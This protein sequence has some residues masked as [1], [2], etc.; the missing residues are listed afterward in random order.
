MK[1]LI[2]IFRN[3]LD[4]GIELPEIR[5]ELGKDPKGRIECQIG[6]DEKEGLLLTIRND[7]NALDPGLFQSI[8]DDYMSSKDEAG[9]VS[10]RGVGLPAVK[11]EAEQMKGSVRVRNHGESGVVFEIRLPYQEGMAW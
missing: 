5:E 7:G 10:G 1:S 6:T 9:L 11:I 8:F 3:S 2:H 4:H